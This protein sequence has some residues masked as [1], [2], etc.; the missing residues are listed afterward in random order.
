MQLNVLLRF[1]DEVECESKAL[2]HFDPVFLLEGLSLDV[3]VC[4]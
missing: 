4:A 3:R 2:I 1:K